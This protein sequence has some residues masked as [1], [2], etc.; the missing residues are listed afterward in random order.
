[1]VCDIYP[2]RPG[3]KVSEILSRKKIESYCPLNSSIHHASYLRRS[4]QEALFCCFCFVRISDE[5][6]PELLKT[7]GIINL[8]FW[9][10]R[11]VVI[12]DQEIDMIRQFLYEYKSVKLE[13]VGMQNRSNVTNNLVISNRDNRFYAQNSTRVMLPSLGYLMVAKTTAINN[14]TPELTLLPRLRSIMDKIVG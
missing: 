11:P 9:L 12:P 5:Q 7:S 14:E 10:N 2:P 13:K 6:I 8:V 1:M 3:K 4:L